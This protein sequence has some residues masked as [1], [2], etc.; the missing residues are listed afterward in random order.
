V[1]TSG[2]CVAG[3]SHLHVGK[4]SASLQCTT[5]PSVGHNKSSA[6]AEIGDRLAVFGHNRLGPK[7]GLCAHFGGLGAHNT[8]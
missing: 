5:E 7:V 1:S 6:V 4:T 3:F 2:E 8:M